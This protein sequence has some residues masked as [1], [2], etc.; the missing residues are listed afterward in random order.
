MNKILLS[1]AQPITY[2]G[3]EQLSIPFM[4]TEIGNSYLHEPAYNRSDYE[5]RLAEDISKRLERA[6]A[7]NGLTMIGLSFS[8]MRVYATKN[9]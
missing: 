6:L 3:L 5:N 4:S 9:A 7:A 8:A 1:Q 2:N